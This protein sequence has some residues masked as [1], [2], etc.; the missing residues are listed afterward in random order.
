[1]A[2]T[3]IAVRKCQES[4]KPSDADKGASATPAD[5]AAT[6]QKV[7]YR[8]QVGAYSVK[9]NAETM[10]KKLKVEGFDAIIVKA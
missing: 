9:A 5:A 6:E 8:V 7:I 10:Q 4:N 1:M 3:K 2:I